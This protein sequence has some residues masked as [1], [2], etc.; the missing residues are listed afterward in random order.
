MTP[1][2]TSQ[3]TLASDLFVR[4]SKSYSSPFPAC[5]G[6]LFSRSP[7]VNR[8]KILGEVAG[9]FPTI[10]RDGVRK[11]LTSTIVCDSHQ[12]TCVHHWYSVFFVLK[13]VCGWNDDNQFSPGWW[14]QCP[15]E[16]HGQTMTGLPSQ[17]RMEHGEKTSSN[18]EPESVILQLWTG[19][20]DPNT[21]N[22]GKWQV[23]VLCISPI[24]EIRVANGSLYGSLS[25]S[26]LLWKTG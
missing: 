8:S 1:S 5:F 16:S 15:P 23:W 6:P 22:L 25:C 14:S 12:M 3:H 26:A 21:T 18:Q 20:A 9:I 4:D 11:M 7:G 19:V 13:I 17:D 10:S 2:Q 24:D